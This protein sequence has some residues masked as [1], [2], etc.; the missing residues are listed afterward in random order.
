M[1]A[2]SPPTPAP[3][4]QTQTTPANP[5]QPQTTPASSTQRSSQARG[6]G[7]NAKRGGRA[8]GA[9]GYNPADCLALV[10]AVKQVLPLGSQEWTK[11][12]DIYN[13][14]ATENNRMAREVDSLKMKFRNLV[15]AKKPTGEAVCPAWI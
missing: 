13:K 8:P 7:A 15:D 6:K 11:V 12:L 5:S 9:Q 1:D 14:Y 4:G 3:P 10:A 2:D